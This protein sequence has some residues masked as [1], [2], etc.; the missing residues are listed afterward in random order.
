MRRNYILKILISIAVLFSCQ[1][2]KQD[3]TYSQKEIDSLRTAFTK[4][5]AD[6]DS[7]FLHASWSPLI[8]NDKTEFKGLNYFP[9]DPTWRFVGP[10]HMYDNPDSISIMGS[11]HGKGRND[12]RPALKYGYFSFN[13]QGKKYS[14]EI[15]KILPQKAGSKGYLF[16]GFWDKTSGKE[17]YPGGRYI[18]MQKTGENRYVVD[19]NYAYNPFCAYNHRY[20]C[21][22]PPLENRLAVSVRAGEKM[23]KEH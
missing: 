16:L 21:A 6:K 4:Y 8:D 22:I 17:T 13:R 15:I 11:Q 14:L 7:S 5:K 9:Y 18:N 23:Y 12:L 20:S 3:A 1:T 10:I 2:K 19:F